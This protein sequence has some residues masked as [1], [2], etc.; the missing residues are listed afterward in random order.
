MI[1]QFLELEIRL[2]ILRYSRKRVLQTVARLSDQT[3]E[4]LEHEIENVE[5]KRRAKKPKPTVLEIAASACKEKPEIAEPL[6]N[7]AVAFQNRIFL[8]QLRDV[9]RFL[10]RLGFV[11]GKLKSRVDSATHLFRSLAGLSREELL[12]LIEGMNS[13]G[14]SDFAMLARAIMGPSAPKTESVVNPPE[15]PLKS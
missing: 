7:L 10:D 15:K 4:D 3:L 9:Q 1:D 13:P 11:H 6:R 5:T 12:K 14:D 8:P 2:L